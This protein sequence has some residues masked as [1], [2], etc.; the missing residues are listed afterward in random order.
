[1]TSTASISIDIA[2]A[3]TRVE[4]VL[5]EPR[6]HLVAI[7]SENKTPRDPARSSHDTLM[8][9]ICCYDNVLPGDA[10]VAPG[11][12]AWSLFCDDLSPFW[13]LR[14][15]GCVK[16]ADK[17][18]FLSRIVGFSYK[19]NYKMGKIATISAMGKNITCQSFI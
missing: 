17:F 1:V 6:F 18:I 13:R 8:L 16:F 12:D 7:L 10:M 9:A 3:G 4:L 15:S 19:R 14:G 2:R 11:T 5:R